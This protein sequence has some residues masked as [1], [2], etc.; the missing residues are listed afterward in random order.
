MSEMML[1]RRKYETCVTIGIT[2]AVARRRSSMKRD[3]LM[4]NWDET[5]NSR[6][7]SKRHFRREDS[8]RERKKEKEKKKLSLPTVS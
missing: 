3:A 1:P 5:S 2:P 8:I 7:G 4:G 6:N